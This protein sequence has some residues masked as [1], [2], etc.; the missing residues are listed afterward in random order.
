[1]AQN[2]EAT[3]ATLEKQASGCSDIR[4]FWQSA[5]LLLAIW[6]SGMIPAAGYGPQVF[7]ELYQAFDAF[8]LN[9]RR[10]V[11]ARAFAA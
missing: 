9:L 8:G 10:E 3:I 5:S 7:P 11:D 6:S 4:S 2:L 1:M